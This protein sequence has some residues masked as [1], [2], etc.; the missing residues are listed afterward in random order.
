MTPRAGGAALGLLAFSTAIIA[1][2][3]V[4]NPVSLIL[5]R[6]IWAMFVFFVIGLLLGWAAQVVVR[7]HIKDREELLF[8]SEDQQTDQSVPMEERIKST[9]GDVKPMGT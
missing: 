7:E 5:S 8:G 3:W 6:A 1:G 4:R 2:L 9:E